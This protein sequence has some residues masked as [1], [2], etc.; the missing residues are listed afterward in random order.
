MMAMKF[1]SIAVAA[2]LAV[3]LAACSQDAGNKETFGTLGGAALGGLLGSQFGGGT[4]KL[5]AVGAGV[6][7]GGLAGREIGRSLDKAD[8]AYAQRAEQ[9]AHTAPVGQQITWS[10]PE[11]GHSGSVTPVRQGVDQ[12][13]AT[14][15]EYQTTVNVGGKSEQ[16]YG[17]ACR[18]ADGSW[19]I[20]N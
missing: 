1:R 10:N 2:A 3:S 5:V 9:Q 13:G 7:I 17:T 8:M 15:R 12:S 16:A 14:C 20:V 18:Q 6:L 4:G 19:K 11:S